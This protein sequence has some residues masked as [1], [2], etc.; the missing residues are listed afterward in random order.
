MKPQPIDVQA[1]QRIAGFK[2][3]FFA[4]L[5]EKISVLKSQNVEVIRLDMGAPDLPP[6]D[7]I[8][9]SMLESAKKADTHSYTPSGGT[10]AYRDA[11]ASYY[12]RRF[13]V[14]L[15]PQKETL[16]LI[17]SKE[18]IFNLSQA[19][20]DPE[21]VTLTPDPGYPV[22][23]ASGLIAG[24]KMY[25]FPLLRENHFLPDLDAIP[26]EIAR[27][28]KI[29]WLN[30]PNN[31]T[32]AVAGLD[33]FEK[34]VE[35]AE[36]YQILIAHD[37]PYTDVCFDGYRAPSILQVNG[38]KEVA[39]EFNSLSETYNMAGWRLGMVVGNPKV[40]NL[41]NIYKSQVDSSHFKPVF[42][43]GITALTGDQTWLEERNL[44]YQ[45]RRDIIVS[46]LRSLGFTLDTPQAAIYVWA[47]LPP[48]AGDCVDFCDRLLRQT[49]VSTT[50]GVVYGAY[51]E[52]FL[53]ISLGTPTPRIEEAMSRM[54]EWMKKYS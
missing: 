42:D 16:G 43:G 51:G 13:D 19:L 11:I 7:F 1:A 41:L 47:K 40:I 32:G 34:A 52:G 12:R 33:F 37:A 28:A 27:K 20:L 29:L 38:A 22:Y 50:P 6:P 4:A 26:Q 54:C 31:P 35:F 23:K 25:S 9:N 10:P 46:T 5:N 44:V 39:V 14:V 15:D 18:G 36:R 30:Y 48:E 49:G 3:Y 53:R 2:P 24:S 45:H 21:D 17:G 8:I